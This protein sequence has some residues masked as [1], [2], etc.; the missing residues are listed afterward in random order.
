FD[1]SASY[2]QDG[3]NLEFA[4]DLNADGALGAY[5]S[6]PQRSGNF[7]EKGVYYVGLSVRDDDGLVDQSAVAVSIYQLSD[8]KQEFVANGLA[9]G[10]NQYY[11]LAEVDGHPAVAY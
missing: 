4:F 9:Y 11:S 10:A 8:F 2:D 3:G 6:N 5:N 1:A 7:S